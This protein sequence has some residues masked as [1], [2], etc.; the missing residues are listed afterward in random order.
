M[1]SRSLKGLPSPLILATVPGLILFTSSHRT[2]P[3]RSAEEKLPATLAPVMASIHCA[4]SFSAPLSN[5]AATFS[6]SSASSPYSGTS[7][8][9]AVALAGQGGACCASAALAGG[10]AV[11]EKLCLFAGAALGDAAPAAPEVW[12]GPA[13]LSVVALGRTMLF[14]TSMCV[15][16]MAPLRP[17][18]CVAGPSSRLELRF[19]LEASTTPRWGPRKSGTDCC[20]APPREWMH[21]TTDIRFFPS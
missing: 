21:V 9:P 18:L 16:S 3:D 1:F 2:W 6:A 20:T 12:R 11:P 8:S 10:G 4:A 7:S 17:P 5:L 14:E 19:A 13:A 15:L